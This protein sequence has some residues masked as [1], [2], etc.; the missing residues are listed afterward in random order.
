MAVQDGERRPRRRADRERA[1]GQ[2]GGHA[3]HARAR[4]RPTCG[5]PPRSSTR[6]TTAWSRAGELSLSSVKRV[7][8]HP[9]ATAQCARFLRERLAGRRARDARPPPPMRC[10]RCATRPTTRASRSA[11]GWPPSCTTATSLADERRGP[12]GQ[13]DALRLARRRRTRRASPGADAKTSIVFWGGGDQSPGWLVDVLREF[14]GPRREPDADRVA[15]AADRARALHVLRGP[16]GRAPD[17]PAVGRGAR[18]RC[19]ATSRSCGYSA[20]IRG[21]PPAW[22]N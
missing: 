12:P 14:A 7:V 9:Q 18:R 21:E 11:R 17:E 5:S 2:R 15:A 3:R 8:S 1:R 10:C 22:L 4:G 19:A 20:R 6:S 16:R 13:R